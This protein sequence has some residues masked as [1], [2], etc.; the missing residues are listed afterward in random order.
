[1]VMKVWTRY[2][3]EESSV[4]R[5]VSPLVL[6]GDPSLYDRC[7]VDT[8]QAPGCLRHGWCSFELWTFK[9]QNSKPGGLLLFCMQTCF[10]SLVYADS[11]LLA[12]N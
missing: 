10:K 4:N 7:P 5:E 1:M 12:F 6:R 2:N 3:L 9:T 8:F 11:P